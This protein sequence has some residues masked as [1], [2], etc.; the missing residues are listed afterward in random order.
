MKKNNNNRRDT[1]KRRRRR[2]KR[3]ASLCRPT[4]QS[5]LS[6]FGNGTPGGY[7]L[8]NA[9]SEM[10]NAEGGKNRKIKKDGKKK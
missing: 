8:N 2:R 6:C 4:F 5:S 3:I 1:T 7:H 9:T 10:E